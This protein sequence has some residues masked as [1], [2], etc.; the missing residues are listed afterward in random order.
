MLIN[1][2]QPLCAQPNVS[3]VTSFDE[4]WNPAPGQLELARPVR[5]KG[6]VLYYDERWGMLWLFDGVS[7]G[8]VSTEG[9]SLGLYPGDSI[10]IEARTIADE[11]EVNMADSIVSVVSPGVLPDSVFPS[12]SEL[13]SEVFNN[14]IV[15][16]EGYVRLIEEVDQH[17]KMEVVVASEIVEVTVILG[18]DEEI[19]LFFEGFVQ[20]DGVLAIP[21]VDEDSPSIPSIF[22]NNLD[23]IKLQ[24]PSLDFRFRDRTMTIGDLENIPDGRR[25]VIEGQV[26]DL[27]PGES[28]SVHD[29]SGSAQVQIWQLREVG[30]GAIVEISGLVSRQ[31]GVIHL[32][33][34]V[35]REFLRGELG[36]ETNPWKL[37]AQ[38]IDGLSERTSGDPLVERFVRLQGIVTGIDRETESTFYYLQDTTG[39]VE[40]E[41]GSGITSLAPSARVDLV[42][43]M[44]ALQ[45]R[46][47]GTI[48]KVLRKSPGRYPTPRSI[49]LSPTAFRQFDDEFSELV[50]LVTDVTPVGADGL[51]L[52]V[53]NSRGALNVLCMG[54]GSGDGE[55]WLESMIM[56]CGVCRQRDD[57]DSGQVVGEILVSD[58]DLIKIQKHRE[59]DPFDV[60]NATVSEL[61]ESAGLMLRRR[62]SIRGFVTHKRRLD[63]VYVA[64]R[65][66]GLMVRLRDAMELE[67]GQGVEVSGFPVWEGQQLAFQRA[68]VRPYDSA[69]DSPAPLPVSGFERVRNDLIGLPVLVK[70]EVIDFETE[71]RVPMIRLLSERAVISLE[72][73][74]GAPAVPKKSVISTTAV[75]LASYDE[76]GVPTRPRLVVS[77]LDGIQVVESAP[78]L[79][80]RQLIVASSTLACLVLSVWFWNVSLRRRVAQQ[81]MEIQSRHKKEG[82]LHDRFKA[83]VESANDLIFSCDREGSIQ[84][85]SRAGKTLLGYS[86]DEAIRLNLRDLL[87]PEFTESA[88]VLKDDSGVLSSG[89]SRQ[90]QFRR[91]DGSVF[92][93]DLGLKQLPSLSGVSGILGVVRDVSQQRAIELELQRAKTAAEEADR[94]KSEFLANMSHEIRTP[95]NGVIG[96]AQLLMDS[97]LNSDQ[98]GFVD[99]I[100]SSGETLIKVI[101]DILDFS[102]FESGKVTLDP[103][104]FNPRHMFEHIVDSLD[105]EAASK[106]LYLSLYLPQDLPRILIGDEVRIRQVLWNLLGNA[107]KFT[108]QGGIDLQVRVR[109]DAL[110]HCEFEVRDSGIGMT[111]EQLTRAFQPFSQADA[112]TTRRFGGTGLGL[113]ICQQLVKAMDGELRVES[114]PEKGSSFVFSLP[115]SIG[116]LAEVD[117]A[118]FSIEKNGALLVEDQGHVDPSLKRSLLDLGFHVEQTPL[119]N[120]LARVFSELA[121]SKDEVVCFVPYRLAKDCE[122][123]VTCIERWER[124]GGRARFFTLQR[125][126]ETEGASDAHFEAKMIRFP[127][128]FAELLEALLP[129]ES[130]ERASPSDTKLPD[131]SLSR[132]LNVL[133]AEDSKL[134]RRVIA[135]QLKRL[136]HSA[137][138]VEDGQALLDQIDTTSYDVILMDCQMPQIDGYEATRRLRMMPKHKNAKIIALTAAARDEDQKR[139]MQAGMDDF[140]SKPLAIEHLHEVLLGNTTPAPAAKV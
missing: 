130:Q 87:E 44:E 45:G 63:E 27:V 116:E 49:S 55:D 24:K 37:P 78:F 97:P 28:M 51:R 10:L 34:S 29:S 107:V 47:K 136:G 104:P 26:D 25:V 66:G 79:S 127:F 23:Q 93:G 108:R 105:P 135:A 113:A 3:P 86:E 40:L 11:V 68:I 99:T 19:P 92:W 80:A 74:V 4:L 30:I 110:A 21:Q 111:P 96:M 52:R 115:L 84:F 31:A 131:L 94:A 54:V 88:R 20:I 95:M 122:E 2:V 6:Q 12:P 50:G 67:V 57:P 126:C 59:D 82:I 120:S 36:S 5:L 69:S 14:R 91:A 62:Q 138:L 83:L 124:D 77:D 121:R 128:R 98:R 22:A 7:G 42:V 106:G 58:P 132:S 56:V 18:V 64:D 61:R 103:Q 13:R 123:L 90:V 102:K 72:L 70:G 65:S 8:Y 15:N 76:F 48:E 100:Q 117:E 129:F 60:P 114:E 53:Q 33:Q 101:N 39:G 81:L 139:C 73:P 85:F 9:Q 119:S 17:L 134:N 38:R 41:A 112:S 1:A 118:L 140:I 71:G 137:I 75:Y 16:V 125:R 46:A 35:F 133:V 32:Q 109:L 43:R 89:I